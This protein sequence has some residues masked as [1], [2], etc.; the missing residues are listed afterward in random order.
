VS[1]K[2]ELLKSVREEINLILVKYNFQLFCDDPYE[3]VML[4]SLEEPFE[5]IE[6]NESLEE[7]NE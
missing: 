5:T 6:F 3:L 4:G 1:F 2:K 7:M